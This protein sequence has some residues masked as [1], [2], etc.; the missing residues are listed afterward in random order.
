MLSRQARWGWSAVA[1]AGALAI[2]YG[3]VVLTGGHQ[4]HLEP[5]AILIRT[6]A[7]LLAAVWAIVFVVKIWRGTD[8]FSR[9]A[10]KFAWLWGGTIGLLISMPVYAFVRMGGIHLFDANA[11]GLGM[12]FSSGYLLAVMFQF[13]GFLVVLTVWRMTKR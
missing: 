10:Q 3:S 7:S 2:T 4:P 13:I 11:H 12:A 9:E 8:E 5:S 6:T 1:A